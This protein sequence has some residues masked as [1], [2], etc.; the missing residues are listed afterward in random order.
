MLVLAA[1]CLG[2]A[3]AAPAPPD[4]APVALQFRGDLGAKVL[5]YWFDTAQDKERGGYLL[6]DDGR[7][8]RTAREK[9]LV[10]QSRM[11]WGFAHAHLKGFSDGRRN[12]LRAAEQGYRFLLE[13][14]LDPQH[15]GY[16][17]K[18][19]LAG[20]QVLN[21][22]KILYGEAFVIYAFV[23]YYRA[24]GDQ[25]ALRR[26]L[27]LYQTLQ[28]RAYDRRHGGWLEHFR[29]DWQPILKPES[30]TEVEVAGYKS[31]NAHLHLMEALA[32][33]YDASRD[34]AVGASLAEA[35]RINAT[36]FYPNDAGQSA[37]HRQPDWKQVTDPKSAGLSYGHN[38]EFA[39]LMIRAQTVLKRKPA[40]AHFDAHLRHALQ[41]G[42]DYERG[43]LYNRGFDNQPASDRDKVWWVQSE[44][45]AAFTDALKHKPNPAQAGALEKLV[46][47][48]NAH[49]AD[50]KDG[51]WYDT[52]AADGAPKN[53]AKAHSWKANYHDVRALVK[54]VEAFAPT[55]P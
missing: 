50:P 33:L 46:R 51:I 8:G 25:D 20:T 47:F 4:F 48:I 9:Q 41:Y 7:G 24:S 10:S 43:G 27:D 12:Y 31:A 15:G 5:P 49:Q 1:A 40:W 37:F 45:L 55:R 30:G 13:H 16:F 52:V 6:A 53:P 11:V 42:Y 23:E 32:E 29:R 2:G 34:K 22:R 36:W 14:F 38:V 19:D 28:A 18:T 21:D 54:F 26:A 39:W 35:I 17:W 44:M 3:A